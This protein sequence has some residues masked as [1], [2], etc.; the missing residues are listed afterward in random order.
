MPPL[1]APNPPLVPALAAAGEQAV[2]RAAPPHWE[3]FVAC[4]GAKPGYARAG[5]ARGAV[6]IATR[7]VPAMKSGVVAIVA[8]GV[9]VAS[10]VRGVLY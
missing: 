4:Q 7:G 1:T 2:G 9:I 10:I 8:A 5:R 3:S 6:E